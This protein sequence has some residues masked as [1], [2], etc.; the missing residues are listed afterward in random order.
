M[1]ASPIGQ[2]RFKARVGQPFQWRF[3]VLDLKTGKETALPETR[4][5]DDQVA[6][7]DNNRLA[8]GVD[9][10]VMEIPADG[11]RGPRRLLVRA[12]NPNRVQ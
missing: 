3:H 4:S 5:V 9:E 1:A 12:T 2:G 7:L 11:S 8:Y 6:W 10:E